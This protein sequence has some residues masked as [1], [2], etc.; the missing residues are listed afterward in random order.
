M[1]VKFIRNKGGGSARASID[2]L[3]GKDR[4]REYA[5][6]LSGNPELTAQL[7]DSLDF[8][9][10]YTVGVLSFAESNMSEKAK[11]EIIQSF[12]NTLMAGLEQD[13]Y[14]IC[15]IEHRD[16]D[17][18]ELNFLIP[19]VELGTGKAFNPYFDRVDRGL[20]DTWKNVINYDYGLKDPND[21][22]NRQTLTSYKD[23]PKEK[24]EFSQELTA[25]LE[26]RILAEEIHNRNDVIKSIEDLGLEIARKTMKSISIKDP[27]GGRNIRLRGEIYEQT[28]RYDQDYQ[29]TN[30]LKSYGYRETNRQRIS[31]LRKELHSR[32][33]AK[34]HYNGE[35]FRSTRTTTT[36]E[37]QPS[38]HSQ[39]FDWSHIRSEPSDHRHTIFDDHNN[40]LENQ[41][42]EIRISRTTRQTSEHT[43]INQNTIQNQ[44]I[45]EQRSLF[46]R[47]RKGDGDI[48]QSTWYTD[49]EDQEI[50]EKYEQIFSPLQRTYSRIRTQNDTTNK[51]SRTAEHA[52][53]AIDKRK[54]DVQRAIRGFNESIRD[55]NTQLLDTTEA[56]TG[57]DSEIKQRKQDT[58]RAYQAI[59]ETNPIVNHS[60]GFDFD[61]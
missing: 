43:T 26:Q 49:D 35:R 31:E 20:V 44:P 8:K 45:G 54:S 55:A 17:R 41:Q 56:I 51:L 60:R 22:A 57:Y 2:Y 10:K 25:Y 11:N 48:Y 29:G 40:E 47:W 15:W 12:E 4:N 30:R 3:L 38:S 32:T 13:Q 36:R 23:L 58:E 53:R 42:P 39:N 14:N 24:R 6:V 33:A 16:K 34:A 59:R 61:R 28:F 46:H 50:G 21:P 37:N 19:K 27:D 5:R 52:N 18:L 9:N 7:A 1:I